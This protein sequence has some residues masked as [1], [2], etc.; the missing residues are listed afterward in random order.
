LCCAAGCAAL[1]VVLTSG[2]ST[3]LVSD[4]QPI[5]RTSAAERSALIS[6]A[7]AVSKVDWPRYERER[8]TRFQGLTGGDASG[9]SVVAEAYVATLRP[10]AGR[11][12]A[13][14]TS[15]ERK[16]RAAEALIEAAHA[17]ADAVRPVA[18]DVSIVEDAIGDLR[19]SRDIYVASLKTIARDSAAV[20]NADIKTLKIEFNETISELGAAA[21]ALADRVA[22][23][24]TKTFAKPSGRRNLSSS[25]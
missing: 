9:K 16:L 3:V 24:R 22:S 18:A 5:E 25:L 7:A 10:G 21:D 14:Q 23:D 11:A 1:F 17:A 8:W 12:A 13:V 4:N 20:D 19:E 6:A 2:C 15:A